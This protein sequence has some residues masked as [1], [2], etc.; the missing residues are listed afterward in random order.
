MREDTIDVDCRISPGMTNAAWPVL[1]RSRRERLLVLFVLTGL[2]ILVTVATITGFFWSQHSARNA[3]D[4]Y[5]GTIVLHRR[6]DTC[7]RLLFDNNSG[8]TIVMP[9]S[10]DGDTIVD[11]DGHPVLS[12]TDPRLNAISR[13]FSGR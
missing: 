13:S 12:G 6:G 4:A 8:K 1:L 11:A 7:Q 5:T 2:V 3:S 10:C 9:G